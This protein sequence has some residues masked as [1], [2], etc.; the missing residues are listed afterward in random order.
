MSAFLILGLGLLL[1]AS[2]PFIA[3]GIL[4]LM[5]GKEGMK[6]LGLQG[7]KFILAH[8]VIIALLLI[9]GESFF[10][11]ITATAAKDTMLSMWATFLIPISLVG[12][13]LMTRRYIKILQKQ[14]SRR[15]KL[16]WT[17]GLLDEIELVY[18]KAAGNEKIEEGLSMLEKEALSEAETACS[19]GG[20]FAMELGQVLTH[21]QFENMPGIDKETAIVML[22]QKGL[23]EF[24]IKRGSATIVTKFSPLIRETLAC[25]IWG[26]LNRLEKVDGTTQDTSPK[27][28]LDMRVPLGGRKN[29]VRWEMLIMQLYPWLS[30]QESAA[31]EEGFA[32]PAQVISAKPEPS[33]VKKTHVHIESNNKT[34]LIGYRYDTTGV[35][36]YEFYRGDVKI[37]SVS[38]LVVPSPPVMIHGNGVDWISDS[39][40]GTILPGLACTVVD[41]SNGKQV[42]KMVYVGA[43]QFRINDLISVFCGDGKYTFYSDQTVIAIISRV[44][45]QNKYP[46]KP[47]NADNGFDYEPYFEI[48][49]CSEME[50][51]LMIFILAFPML[52]VGVCA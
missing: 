38:S 22:S 23:S 15:R 42:F 3:H 18:K 9:W 50:N 41:Q 39:K 7:N 31:S 27:W 8:I 10:S 34:S 36:G 48:N 14:E 24:D 29:L 5:Y 13:G 1:L 44:N 30:V 35:F 40:M 46:A 17:S 16:E 52:K 20:L 51:E 28:T 19:E 26:L 21:D 12:Y 37:C 49:I 11:W 47:L 2:L 4:C 25:T 32:Q 6:S 33:L 43:G 45:P